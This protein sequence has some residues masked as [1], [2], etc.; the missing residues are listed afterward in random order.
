MKYLF[1][2]LLTLILQTSNCIAMTA[3]PETYNYL[4]IPYPLEKQHTIQEPSIAPSKI[5]ITATKGSDLFT[6]ADSSYQVDNAPRL[7]FAPKAD[8][9]FSAKVSVNLEKSFDGAAL[10]VYADEGN[11][12]KLLLER[13]NS[14]KNGI[15]ST[16]VYKGGD[17]AYHI[18]TQREYSHLKI[19]RKGTTYFFYHSEDSRHW[20]YLRSFSLQTS[21]STRIGF[22]AQSP[23]GPKVQALFS[24][25]NFEEKTIT[26]YMQGT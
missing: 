2:A 20:S 26:D 25:I 22:L 4:L 12:A 18:E 6:N 11:W 13:F 9:I 5:T 24:D 23:T 21:K 10:I 3:A 8:F 7:I 1:P 17:D 14:G 16:V 19:A 15:A